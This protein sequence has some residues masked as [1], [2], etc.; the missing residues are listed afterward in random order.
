MCVRVSGVSQILMFSLY[1]FFRNFKS[2]QNSFS[3]YTGFSL[4]FTNQWNHSVVFNKLKRSTDKTT[5]C[6]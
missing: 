1:I 6:T 4:Q 5:N 2:I 3:G